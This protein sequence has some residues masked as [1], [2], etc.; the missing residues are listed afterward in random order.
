MLSFVILSE[1]LLSEYEKARSRRTYVQEGANVRLQSQFV[2]LI[3]A[4]L[5]EYTSFVILSEANAVSEVEGPHE[6]GSAL[7]EEQPYDSG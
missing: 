5:S 1:V 2:N 6:M 7:W 3:E 4:T